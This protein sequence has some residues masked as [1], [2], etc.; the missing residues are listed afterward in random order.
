MGFVTDIRQSFSENLHREPRG[1]E[2]YWLMIAYG[3]VVVGAAVLSQLG[4]G[5]EV[6][7]HS[8][9]LGVGVGTMG[10]AEVVPTDRIRLA[11]NFRLC[12][13]GG[14]LLYGAWIFVPPLLAASY[15]TQLLAIAAVPFILLY[16]WL[17]YKALK[18]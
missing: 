8:I 15:E 5:I 16:A 6:E 14:F 18:A 4:A 11:R 12:A 13:Y 17:M 7:A 2:G 10:A 9:L 3:A 1:N